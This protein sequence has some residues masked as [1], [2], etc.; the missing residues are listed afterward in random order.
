[1]KPSLAQVVE[2]LQSL[3]SLPMVVMELLQTM[4]EE[5]VEHRAAGAGHRQ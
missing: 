4:G 1:M 3:P 2:S 5:D